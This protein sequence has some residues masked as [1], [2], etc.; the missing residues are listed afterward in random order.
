FIGDPIAALRVVEGALFVVSGLMRAEVQTSR[1]WRSAA[2]GNLSR[3][4]FVNMLDRERAD[5]F[6]DLRALHARLSEHCVPNQLPIGAEHERTGIVDLLHMC[7]YMSPE[8]QRE[9]KATEIAA[10]MQ[11]Q[12][13]EYHTRLLDA[14][15]ETDEA[16]MERYL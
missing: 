5:F 9:G 4:V 11:A 2:E 3:A 16:L 12:V 10:E 1:N 6:P 7:A 8:A 14:V 13:D 15:V